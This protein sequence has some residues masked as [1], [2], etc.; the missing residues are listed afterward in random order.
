MNETY[1]YFSTL[2]YTAT[3]KIAGSLERERKK[4]RKN[5]HYGKYNVVFIESIIKNE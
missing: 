4:I 2:L 3:A 5:Q 1:P